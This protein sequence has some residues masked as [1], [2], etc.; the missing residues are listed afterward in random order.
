MPKVILAALLALGALFS[1][2][3]AQAGNKADQGQIFTALSSK[4]AVL[5]SG[6]TRARAQVEVISEAGGRCKAVT[7]EV[8]QAIGPDGVFARLDDTFVRLDLEAN[9]V[10]QKRLKSRVD[11]LAKEVARRVK[12][13]KR[14]SEPQSKLDQLQQEMDQARLQLQG[15]VVKGKILKER[16]DRFKVKAPAGWLVLERKVEPG[17]WVKAGDHLAKVGDFSKLLVPM[18]F[19]QEEFQVLKGMPQPLTLQV[20]AEG[21]GVQAR[22][23]K[24]NPGFDSA[25]RKIKLDLVIEKGLWE[26][27]GGV[28]VELK[29]FLPDPAGAVLVPAQALVERYQEH[30]LTRSDGK[31]VRVV[32]LGPGPKE[33]KRVF[34]PQVKAGMNFLLRPER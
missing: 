31:Q 17:Q 13:V 12:L 28:R 29:L 24:I 5:L 3:P 4:K 7:A 14:R 22:V 21:H 11:Y 34:S 6:F 20:P 19:S 33:L 2:G 16:K 15:L 30:W 32:Y 10:E 8:G 23:E 9:A 25:T 18:A 26:M 27:R 1:C